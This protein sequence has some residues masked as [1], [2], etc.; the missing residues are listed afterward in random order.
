MNTVPVSRL[1]EQETRGITSAVK[2]GMRPIKP[3]FVCE[4]PEIPSRTTLQSRGVQQQ[5]QPQ[6]QHHRSGPSPENG[7]F[8]GRGDRHR[9]EDEGKS[10]ERDGDYYRN[11]GKRGG[12]ED[13]YSDDKRQR[14]R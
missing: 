13:S 14:R 2:G 8:Y 1:T 10:R 4:E 6:Q 11:G 12:Y 7:D 3:G 9:Y 5:D